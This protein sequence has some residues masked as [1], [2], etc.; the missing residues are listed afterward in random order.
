MQKA[1]LLMYAIYPFQIYKNTNL[2]ITV[3]GDIDRKRL[4]RIHSY[5]FTSD[6]TKKKQQQQ[7]YN[8]IV[9]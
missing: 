5:A 1:A 4:D 8:V 6:L 7:H 9:T 3:C 2:H